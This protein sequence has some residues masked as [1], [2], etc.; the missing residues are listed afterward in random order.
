MDGTQYMWPGHNR[1]V[2]VE[3]GHRAHIRWPYPLS[4]TIHSNLKGEFQWITAQSAICHTPQEEE[5]F[6]KQAH[7][8]MVIGGTTAQSTMKR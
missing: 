5:T 2:L 1:P 6:T 7:A 8:Q 4:R 3:V